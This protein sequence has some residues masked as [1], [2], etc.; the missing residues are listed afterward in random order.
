[1]R[2][3][4]IT[5]KVDVYS[6]GVITWELLT[7]EDPFA[8]HDDYDTFVNAV[9]GGERPII[10]RWCPKSLEKVIKSC[11]EEDPAKRPTMGEVINQLDACIKDCEQL[12]FSRQIDTLVTDAVG[13]Q[14]WKKCFPN[15]VREI[16]PNLF[17]T[18]KTNLFVNLYFFVFSFLLVGQSLLTN[19]MKH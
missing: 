14:F 11:W 3:Q 6:V 15:K 18:I 8:D 9:C 19:F 10:P 12:D 2:K 5:E 17:G 4:E 7:R 1:M 16:S 13:R